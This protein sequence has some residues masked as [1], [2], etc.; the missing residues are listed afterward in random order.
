VTLARIEIHPETASE[1]DDV[2]KINVEAFRDHPV[3]QQTEQRKTTVRVDS[4]EQGVRD[5]AGVG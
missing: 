4:R 5:R 1:I 3:S 2:R